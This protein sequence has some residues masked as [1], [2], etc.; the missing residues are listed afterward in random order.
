[1]AFETIIGNEIVKKLLNSTIQKNN[2]LHSYLFVGPDGIGKSIFAKEFAQMILCENEITKPCHQCKSCLE[3]ESNNHP[4]FLQINS[5][6]GKSIKI[7]QVRFLQEKIA[8]KP[9]SSN[10][11]V[12]VI[13]DSDLMTREAANSL[14]KTLEEPPAYATLIL[15]TSNESKLLTTIKSRCIKV[16]FQVI[17][18]EQ[19]LQYLRKNNLD[20][21]VTQNMLEMC[22]GSIGKALKLQER[23]DDYAEI[24]EL[25]HK[26]SNTDITEI[27][28]HAEVLYKAKENVMEL[29]DYMNL[30][31]YKQLCQ[32][33][34]TAIVKAIY[35][36]E[37][38]KKRILAN[39]NYD[40]SIDHL[41]LEIW[42]ELA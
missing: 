11:K 31:F 26:I 10:R 9:V 3:M 25:I 37:E 30:L 1:M 8:E 24:E 40:M 33:Q 28:N 39:A 20:A 5:D 21:G 22:E 34:Q 14:L 4:D 23:K 7:E 15:I 27:W 2:I 42:E 41:L 35:S 6:D 12:Y 18:Q 17:E 32:K 13:Y 19:I 38:A 36:V 16:N 29:L